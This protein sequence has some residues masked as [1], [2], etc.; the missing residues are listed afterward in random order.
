[1]PTGDPGVERS[2]AGPTT[3]SYRFLR[4][5]GVGCSYGGYCDHQAPRDSSSGPYYKGCEHDY[6]LE[7]FFGTTGGYILNYRCRKCLIQN[8]VF[9]NTKPGGV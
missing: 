9:S 8:T 5:T 4:G 7:S 6:A 3:C 1:M 2:C